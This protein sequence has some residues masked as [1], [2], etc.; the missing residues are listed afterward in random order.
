MTLYAREMPD[1]HVVALAPGLIDTGMQDYLCEEVD[2]DEFP[3]VQKLKDARG[4][5]NMPG[6]RE[7]AEQIIDLLAD[8][9]DNHESGAFVDIRKL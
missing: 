9:R 4:T 6:P 3:S 8:L 2:S 5:E 7:A 1:T